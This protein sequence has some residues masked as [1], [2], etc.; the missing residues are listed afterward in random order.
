MVSLFGCTGGALSGTPSVPQD[1]QS[2]E[3]DPPGGTD[4]NGA[5]NLTVS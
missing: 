1:S 3:Q 4:E 5:G 2:A